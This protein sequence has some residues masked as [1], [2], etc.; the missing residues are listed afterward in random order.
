MNYKY[1][2]FFK[3]YFGQKSTA[4][5]LKDFKK[6]RYSSELENILQENNLNK[7]IVLDQIHADTGLCIDHNLSDKS[8]ILEYQGDF[9]ITNIKNIGLVVLTADCVPL[10]LIDSK[11]YVAAIVHA[12]WRGSFAGVLEKTLETM[13]DTYQTVFSDV[14]A[15][16][17]PSA[18]NCCY[19]VSLDFVQ[20]FENKFGKLDLFYQRESLIYFDNNQFLQKILK[21]Y[22]ILERNINIENSFCTICNLE[23]CSFRRE[24]E[25][26]KRQ[27]TLVALW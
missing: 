12:G 19:Q 22:G 10:I 18:R 17:G 24:G 5:C 26:A 21:K 9:L 27:I 25:Q 1:R 3:I 13:R 6:S 16:F 14:Q 11:N 8:S 20:K 15:F 2:D 23:Y 7:V 4:L